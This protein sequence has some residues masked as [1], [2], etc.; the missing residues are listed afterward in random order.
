MSALN[1]VLGVLD[2]PIREVKEI[3]GIEIGKE[4]VKQSLFANE[5]ILY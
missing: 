3:K 1:I 4:E 5:M 2:T